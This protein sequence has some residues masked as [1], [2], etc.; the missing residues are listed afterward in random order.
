MTTEFALVVLAAYAAARWL[1]EVPEPSGPNGSRR[2]SGG[3]Q[4]LP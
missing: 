1:G 3:G 4:A 2:D